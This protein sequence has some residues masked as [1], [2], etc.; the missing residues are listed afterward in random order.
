MYVSFRSKF[1]GDVVMSTKVTELEKLADKFSKLKKNAT[2][3]DQDIE[4][5]KKKYFKLSGKQVEKR[6]PGPK[7]G[8][9][10]PK[11]PRV[12]EFIHKV[13]IPG[14]EM[15]PIDI[16]KLIRRIG[17]KETGYRGKFLNS[18]V[19]TSLNEKND[20]NIVQVSRGHYVMDPDAYQKRR[21]TFYQK[22]LVE[23]RA[24]RAKALAERKKVGKLKIK[25][26]SKSRIKPTSKSR[27]LAKV[28]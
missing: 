22:K 11:Q 17:Y 1:L 6:K 15:T 4:K 5:C 14:E 21:A 7:A 27:K 2:K 9:K 13:M 3:I 8:T 20:N 28:S 18:T 16:M 26:I 10:R 24:K 23:I 12:R 19:R 25:P